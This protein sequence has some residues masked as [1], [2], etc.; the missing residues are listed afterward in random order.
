V[1]KKVVGVFV[2]FF[3]R[4]F[5]E[6]TTDFAILFCHRGPVCRG[7]APLGSNATQREHRITRP[8]RPRS[9]VLNSLQMGFRTLA[10]EKRSNSLSAGGGQDRRFDEFGDV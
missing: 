3:V 2:A 7:A 1:T 4:R 5:I 10:L 8:G 9:C 6:R